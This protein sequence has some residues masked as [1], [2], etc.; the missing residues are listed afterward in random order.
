MNNFVT[1]NQAADGG[2]GSINI[3]CDIISSLFLAR[4]ARWYRIT[5]RSTVDALEG[6]KIVGVAV[7]AF[8][9]EMILFTYGTVRICTGCFSM[10]SFHTVHHVL[11]GESDDTVQRTRRI[12]TRS[13]EQLV[14]ASSVE[15]HSYRPALRCRRPLRQFV[16]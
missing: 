10:T 1:N 9:D 8:V 2:Y 16:I 15:I 7:C 4:S 5:T 11:C 6:T 12:G 13:C 14:G 3:V